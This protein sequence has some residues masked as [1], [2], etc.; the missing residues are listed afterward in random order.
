MRARVWCAACAWVHAGVWRPR[1]VCACVRVWAPRPASRTA[2]ASPA[3]PGLG[4]CARADGRGLG[5]TPR[6]YVLGSRRALA[7]EAPRAC[8]AHAR[9]AHLAS[10]PRHLRFVNTSLA[11]MSSPTSVSFTAPVARVTHVRYTANQGFPQCAVV[12]MEQLPALPFTYVVN[13]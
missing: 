4:A 1:L 12:N 10:A 3:W 13:Q 5:T 6:V 8:L 11:R 9:A 2:P 7:V